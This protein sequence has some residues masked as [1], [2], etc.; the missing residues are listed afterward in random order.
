MVVGGTK[1]VD[2]FLGFVCLRF[3]DS[4]PLDSLPVC[5]TFIWDTLSNRRRIKF[6]F[7]FKCL[8]DGFK[9]FFG[10]KK[11][12]RVHDHLRP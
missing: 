3:T 7:F 1:V 4:L 6:M 9:C 12:G 11:L 2:D 5:T 10:P 8:T